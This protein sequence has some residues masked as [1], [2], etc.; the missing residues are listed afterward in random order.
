MVSLKMTL[1]LYQKT[2]FLFCGNPKVTTMVE[3]PT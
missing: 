3:N 1:L 2:G